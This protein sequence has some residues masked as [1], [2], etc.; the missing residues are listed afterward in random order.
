MSVASVINELYTD[1]HQGAKKK[2]TKKQPAASDD[3]TAA[4]LENIKKLQTEQVEADKRFKE[5]VQKSNMQQ[6][7]IEELSKKQIDDLS[8]ENAQLKQNLD[9]EQRKNLEL[10]QKLADATSAAKK[11]LKENTVDDARIAELMSELEI[12]NE[13]L[14]DAQ[15]ANKVAYDSIKEFEDAFAELTRQ[16]QASPASIEANFSKQLKVVEKVLNSEAVFQSKRQKAASL[17]GNYFTDL[18]KYAKEFGDGKLKSGIETVRNANNK[19]FPRIIKTANSISTY[20]PDKK[21]GSAMVSLAEKF[22]DYLR[23]YYDLKSM[24]KMTIEANTIQKIVDEDNFPVSLTVANNFIEQFPNNKQQA[25]AL[26][27]VLRDIYLALGLIVESVKLNKK[28]KDLDVNATIEIPLVRLISDVIFYGAAQLSGKA[29][30][31]VAASKMKEQLIS[32]SKTFGLDL[33]VGLTDSKDRSL[34]EKFNPFKDKSTSTPSA[35]T[36]KPANAKLKFNI[37]KF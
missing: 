9:A 26:V 27:K 21:Y 25:D 16:M 3:K 29:D 24:S 15:Q 37:I 22:R 34:V 20:L 5:Y 31:Y 11:S 36:A 13:E 14:E 18:L 10:T 4:L 30:D 35:A 12:T 23:L 28:E 1:C 6:K 17:F 8:N 7:K 19:I 32:E 2:K 33:Y